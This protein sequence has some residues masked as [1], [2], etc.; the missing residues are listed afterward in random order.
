MP[1]LNILIEE[2]LTGS[3]GDFIDD[4]I[5]I[6]MVGSPCRKKKKMYVQM[7]VAALEESSIE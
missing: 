2:S 3:Q 7:Y 6:C 4:P 5:K 1:H